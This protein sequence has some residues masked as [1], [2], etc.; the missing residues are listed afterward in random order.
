[1]TCERCAGEFLETQRLVKKEEGF[2]KIELTIMTGHK[3]HRMMTYEKHHEE[4][5]TDP[6]CFRCNT[7]LINFAGPSEN[8]KTCQKI[9]VDN[10]EECQYKKTQVYTEEM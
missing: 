6:I 4:E 8:C 7:A 3:V 5:G 1:M 2:Y 9:Y 10:W